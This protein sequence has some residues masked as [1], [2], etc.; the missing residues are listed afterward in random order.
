MISLSYPFDNSAI[1][2]NKRS[3]KKELLA[4]GASR[5][6]KKIAVL[7]GSTTN[8]IVNILELFLLNYG[9]EPEFYQ[10][11]YAQYWQD[12]VFGNE[13]LD[14]F[15]P[16]IV[17]VHTTNRNIKDYETC[18]S[19]TSEEVDAALEKQFNHFEEVWNG[20]K[21]KFHCPVIQNNF[22]MPSYRLLGNRDASDFRGM[23]NF[24][25]RLNEKFY[26][27]AQEN[28]NFY[29]NDINYISASY[30][31]SKWADSTS[32]YMYK[33]ALS[34]QAIPELSFNIANIIKSIYG[35]NKKMFV[36]DMDNTLWGGVV[37]DNG[38]QG[39]EIG[40]ETGIA[41][42]Y[43]EFQKYIKAHKQLGVLLSVN[44]KNDMENAL[45]GLKHPDT[46]LTA[47]DFITIKANWNNKDQNIEEI[48]N[49]IS[50]LPDSFVFVDDN[51]AERGI[52]SAQINGIA[53]P[54][55]D[56]VENY[57]RIL[58]RNAY[59]ELTSF[60]ADDVSRNEMY[61]ANFKRMNSQK[62][63]SD[64]TEYLESLEMKAVIDDFDPVYLNR[65]VQ[66][67]NKS[68]Q[69]NL[70][71]KRYTQA[72]M[73]EV[74]QSSEYIRLYGKLTDKFGDNGVVSVVIGKKEEDTLHMDLWLMS[75]RVLKRNMEFAMLD[76]LVKRAKEE[77]IKTIRG[78][79]YK[80]PKNAMVTDLYT[81]FG[82][83]TVS[84]N[85]ETGD[86]VFELKTENY[87]DK[88]NIIKIFKNGGI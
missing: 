6:K 75:C 11:E 64:Y 85:E 2:K 62:T 38:Q 72:E 24:I 53:V 44:S 5:I 9:I 82:F 26:K 28:E 52:V 41:Q 60:T 18:M 1:L 65:I 4:S 12:A 32:W 68:N 84:R 19:A 46:V 43:Y 8:E 39:I 71:T 30:G 88:N 56:S 21:N 66:L 55:I 36:L 83:E 27:Y 87:T 79:Y 35:K 45:D 10:S 3:I 78:Y 77:G 50:I 49:E 13:A 34:T 42:G 33:Y 20:I 81:V 57:I 25:S 40:Q 54:E 58:D 17:Y 73:D 37:G 76:S 80:S 67:T 48:S 74:L 31:L 16:D 14:S 61:Q 63:F 7:G 29:I 22:E 69:F 86:A 70:T 23:T 15:A 51:P 47:D 59:F